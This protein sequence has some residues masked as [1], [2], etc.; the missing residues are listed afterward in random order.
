MPRKKAE[1]PKT[2]YIRARITQEMKEELRRLLAL[3]GKNES[4]FLREMVAG[5]IAVRS[6]A[7]HPFLSPGSGSVNAP[8]RP[9]VYIG[10]PPPGMAP[11]IGDPPFV[12]PPRSGDPPPGLVWTG[13]VWTGTSPAHVVSCASAGRRA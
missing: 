6:V 9:E 7:P 2:A 8:A 10:D 3:E 4:V 13:T 11:Y 1:R 5:Y 12:A